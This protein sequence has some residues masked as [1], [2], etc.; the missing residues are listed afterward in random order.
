MGKLIGAFP[1]YVRD[2]TPPNVCVRILSR[3]IGS[4]NQIVVTEDPNNAYPLPGFDLASAGS[5]RQVRLDANGRN[6]S[7]TYSDQTL[8]PIVTGQY[9]AGAQILDDGGIGPVAF[10]AIEDVRIRVV[11]IMG[12]DNY[13]F[14][15][16]SG[17]PDP[18]NCNPAE[19]V[20]W[21]SYLTPDLSDDVDM[22]FSIADFSTG[23]MP[24][25][26][27][28]HPNDVRGRS[29]QEEPPYFPRLTHSQMMVP[30][31]DPLSG[32]GIAWFIE[33]GNPP[34]YVRG[35]DNFGDWVERHENVEA[36]PGLPFIPGKELYI[37]VM[38]RDC[39]DNRVDF[40]IP[41]K[42]LD[43]NLDVKGLDFKQQKVR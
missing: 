14:C 15:S 34:Q 42:I 36:V 19:V 30:F 10:H 27:R 17:W 20:E 23:P 8:G 37:R 4:I 1:V 29:N 12:K 3:D 40:R 7:A 6:F 9:L 35:S 2:T 28:F 18:S 16:P 43:Q 24:R 26:I 11:N 39:A 13:S 21:Y 5:D 25:S 41:L 32:P 31:D 22:Y 38:A 33:R